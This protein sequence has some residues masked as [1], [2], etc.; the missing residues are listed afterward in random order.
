[1]ASTR[2]RVP[3]PLFSMH[4]LV[5]HDRRRALAFGADGHLRMLE[6][7]PASRTVEARRL[8]VSVP[9]EKADAADGVFLLSASHALDRLLLGVRGEPLRVYDLASGEVVA[10]GPPAGDWRTAA[11]S[12][13]GRWVIAVGQG[14]GWTMDLSLSQPR[15]SE[16][17]QLHAAENEAGE[18]EGIF[19]D[20][21]DH[22]ATHPAPVPPGE[23]EAFWVAAACYGEVIT[24]RVSGPKGPGGLERV[25]GDTRGFSKGIVYDP[26]EFSM[27]WGA[28]HAFVWNGFGA[29][30]AAVDPATGEMATFRARAENHPYGFIHAVTSSGV[31]ETALVETKDGAF[32]WRVGH[33]LPPPIQA[34]PGRVLALYPGA[35]LE[36]ES[37]GRH[38][39]WH[40]LP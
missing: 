17:W 20:H 12:P 9:A 23:E 19:L 13:S 25:P 10:E 32:L 39:A 11:L 6:I 7:D 14:T 4:V 27:P 40:D 37:E 33:P 24:H 38:L 30:L 36:L 31:D 21:V 26:C 8:P 16:T 3:D 5:R 28:R 34:P 29:G 35:L 22:L 1:M 15:W 18:V 2:V